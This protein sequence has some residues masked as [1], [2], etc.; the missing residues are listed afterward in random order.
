MESIKNIINNLPREDKL[1]LDNSVK[2]IKLKKNQ[3]LQEADTTD[4]KI[5]YVVEGLLRKYLLKDEK[6]L[7]LD[8]YF[9]DD[10]YFPQSNQKNAKT[11]SYIQ[12]LLPSTV[13]RIEIEYFNRMKLYSKNLQSLELHIL[14]SAYFQ[15]I[16]RLETFQTM[17]ATERYLNLM[18]KQPKLIQN[19]PLIYIASFL[20]INNASLSKIRSALR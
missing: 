16:E 11:N 3:L 18:E 8:F 9:E 20:G 1:L 6:E 5:F 19:I 2:K 14:E 12:T 4:N 17:N 10:L 13:Y 15:T 7:T